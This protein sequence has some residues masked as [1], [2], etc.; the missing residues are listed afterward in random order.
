MAN[1]ILRQKLDRREFFVA[2]GL[3]D[4]IAATVANEVG[5]DIVYGS[6]YWL[7]ASALGL[8]DAGNAF[9]DSSGT[10]PVVLAEGQW[11]G[12]EF[13]VPTALDHYTLTVVEAGDY[14][15]EFQARSAAGDWST[16]ARQR[17]RFQWDRQTRVF[18]VETV[19]PATA[20]RLVFD[21]PVHVAQLEFLRLLN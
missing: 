2:P 7:T 21:E 15:W 9:D 16:V 14:A 20:Y 17:A 10:A 3:Q 6:G 18:G 1:P 12:W 19:A 8:P 4:M 11:L 13:E 5:F